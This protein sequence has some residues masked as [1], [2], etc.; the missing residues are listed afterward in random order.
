LL[1]FLL[2]KLKEIN[3]IAVASDL[4]IDLFDF[5]LT[6]NRRITN[7]KQVLPIV[8]A[9]HLAIV[10]H[11][12]PK[13]HE[14]QTL[15]KKLE[16]NF[17][18]KGVLEKSEWNQ[19]QILLANKD[20]KGKKEKTNLDLD[21]L[22]KLILELLGNPKYSNMVKTLS[23]NQE[24]SVEKTSRKRTRNQISSDSGDDYTDISSNSD[25]SVKKRLDF[26]GSANDDTP[27]AK[28]RKPSLI[29]GRE[30]RIKS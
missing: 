16:I 12:F 29:K 4:V 10:K 23:V 14:D 7:K 18:E 9:R 8:C 25:D 21:L 3:I 26:E 30:K 27:S 13:L 17:L 20:K 15:S 1:T 28:P 2:K 19:F 5:K 6:D 24:T 11:C 22:I